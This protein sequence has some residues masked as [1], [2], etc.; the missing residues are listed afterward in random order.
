MQTRTL[1]ALTFA[2]VSGLSFAGSAVAETIVVDDQVQVRD[3]GVDR[4]RR[5]VTMT[6][7]EAKFGAP[8]TK[9][10]AVGSPPITRWDYSG[11]SVFFE[12]DRVIDSVVTSG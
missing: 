11:F 10:D 2:L 7:V 5:G 1:V 3:T 12:H 9:H 8:V 6:Q 4:P